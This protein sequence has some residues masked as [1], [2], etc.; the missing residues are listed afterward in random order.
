VAGLLSGGLGT[1]TT[2]SGAP[3]MIYMLGRGVEPAVVRDT[4]TVVFFGLGVICP[5]ALL[6]TRTTEA[7]PDPVLV[8]AGAP[9]VIAGHLLGRSGFVRLVRGGRYERAVTALLLASVAAGLVGVL[10]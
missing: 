5:L 1:S 3:L 9:I 4:L 2:T 7:I 6:V 8:A 10:A